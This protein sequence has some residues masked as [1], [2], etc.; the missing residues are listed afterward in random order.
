[1]AGSSDSKRITQRCGAG[2]TVPPKENLMAN[3]PKFLVI[4]W[5]DIAIPPISADTH[6]LMGY[7]TPSIDRI[8][9]EGAL[10]S[11]GN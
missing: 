4:F 7:R 1:L 6:G 2:G 11:L 9:K 5:D 3:K 8:A 10:F